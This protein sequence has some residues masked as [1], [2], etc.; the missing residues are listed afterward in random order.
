[1]KHALKKYISDIKKYRKYVFAKA[2]TD[3]KTDVAGSYLGWL[4]WILDPLFF[5]LIYTFVSVIV[6]KTTEPYFSA[7]VFVGS[8][9]FKLFDKTIKKGIRLV[10]SNRTIIK[11]IYIPKPIM[12]LSSLC[13]SCFESCI[14]FAL[15]AISMFLYKVPLTYHCF[16]FIPLAILLVILC[17]GCGMI[18]M[19]CGVFI[20]DLYNVVNIALNFMMYLSGVFFSIPNRI[21]NTFLQTCLLKFNPIAFIIEQLRGSLLYGRG[22]DVNVYLIWFAI[23]IC[24]NIFGLRLVYKNENTYV[25]MLK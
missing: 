25:K 19:H 24:I 21:T 14:S 13:V 18:M 17:Y 16:Q 11:N 15:V 23:A 12:L 3:L 7:F 2:K 22:L 5:M 9:V 10:P 20:E 4:W 8:T 1:M 6:F